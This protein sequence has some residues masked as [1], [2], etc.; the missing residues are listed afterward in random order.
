MSNSLGEMFRIT[1]FGE[2][3][4]PAIGVVIDGCPSG[5]GLKVE[6]IQKALDRRKPVADSGQTARREEDRVEILSGIFQGRTTGSAL[7]MIVHNRDT[8]SGSY[9][10]MRFTPRPGHADYTAYLKFGGFNDFRGGGIFSGRVTAAPVMAGAV[11]AQLLTTLGISIV[12][13]SRQ[14]GPVISQVTEE[15]AIQQNVDSNPLHCVDAE[16]YIK[17]QAAIE[18]ARQ[19]GDSLGGIVEALALGVP[20][21]LGEPYFDSL[22]GQLAK[23]IFAIPAVKGVEFGAGFGVAGLSGSRN[24][25]PWTNRDGRIVTDRNNAGGIL[26]GI[27][28]GR[29]ILARVAVK[30]T[31]SIALPQ[32][33]VDLRNG[34]ESR[35]SVTGRHDACIVP[36]AAVVVEAMTAIVICDF[37]LRSGILRRILK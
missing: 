4:G 8:D 9:E 33:T 5:L 13:H 2:S 36:R 23:A 30:P 10:A 7:T 11:A 29:T 17:M 6:D 32:M 35:I 20:T 21:G 27:S 22:E 12:A 15:M 3:H 14:I 18:K 34:Q 24:N 28:N 16:A 25:D 26:G 31:P 1:V 19:S 37:A